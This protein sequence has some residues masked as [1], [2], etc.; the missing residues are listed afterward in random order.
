MEAF[1]QRAKLASNP[2]GVPTG[3]DAQSGLN[4]PEG[5]GGERSRGGIPQGF[6]FGVPG[7]GILECCGTGCGCV[8]GIFF[9]G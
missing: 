4:L 3:L 6:K 9:G 1:V 8:G 5:R 2:V 7:I